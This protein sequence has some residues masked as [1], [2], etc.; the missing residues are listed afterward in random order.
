MRSPFDILEIPESSSD[1][2]IKSA[3]LN[4]IHQYPPDRYPEIFKEIK[5]AY[6]KVST[7]RNRVSHRLFHVHEPDVNELLYIALKTKK[8]CI[9]EDTLL[10]L[11][12]DA[13]VE[14][15]KGYENK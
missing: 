8:K 15:L 9:S 3:Y 6:E 7:R 12:S 4:M 1:A 14:R 13:V 10:K 11:I 5:D 2:Q